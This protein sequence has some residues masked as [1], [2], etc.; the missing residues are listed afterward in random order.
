M[1]PK[2]WGKRYGGNDP[3][4]TDTGE[5]VWMYRNGQRVRFYTREGTQVGPE[6]SNVAPAFAYVLHHHWISVDDTE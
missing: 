2:I 4:L 5:R 3:Y 1:G 6:Q